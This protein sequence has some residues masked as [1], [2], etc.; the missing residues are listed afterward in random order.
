MSHDKVL[1]EAASGRQVDSVVV[2]LGTEVGLADE[3][4]VR[5]DLAIHRVAYGDDVCCERVKTS[6]ASGYFGREAQTLAPT[7]PRHSWLGR[8]TRYYPSGLCSDLRGRPR[9]G[10]E[11]EESAGGEADG[12]LDNTSAA[13]EKVSCQFVRTFELCV[14]GQGG[15]F[16][17]ETMAWFG[18]SAKLCSAKR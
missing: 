9:L 16:L 13:G 3:D 14:L 10:V 11:G 6:D 17:G 2:L 15:S 1:G 8:K 4:F 12:L 5:G 18:W 7:S